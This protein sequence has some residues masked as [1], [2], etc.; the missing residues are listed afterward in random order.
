MATKHIRLPNGFGRITKISN[1]NLR[2]PYRAMVTIGFGEDGRPIGKILKPQ[3]YFRTYNEAYQALMDYHK[4]PVDLM[5]NITVKELYDQWSQYYFKHYKNPSAAR[6]ME[7]AWQYLH[8]YYK[9][10]VAD[11]RAKTIRENLDTAHRIKNGERIEATDATKQKIKL[12][13]N[14]MLDYAVEYE[15]TDRNWAR[16]MKY[17]IK[18]DVNSHISF[19]KEEMETLWKYQCDPYV[20]LVLI[21]CY[22]GWRPSE[23]LEMRLENVNIN[24]MTMK[25]GMKTEAG[26][27]RVVPIPSRIQE[28][29][30]NIYNESLSRGSD[31]FVSQP[32]GKPVSYVSYRNAFEKLKTE[33]QLND[34]HRPHDA[35]KQFVTMAKAA[36]VDDYAIKR[37]V[38]HVIKD[39]TESLYTDRSIEWL[40]TEIE[41][42]GV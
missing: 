25:G 11:I 33:Y 30:K 21:Q 15:M 19:T 37:I 42:I 3:G 7:A 38:G 1:K 14:R 36:G 40:R 31:Y 39:I 13:W 26:R 9:M 24:E 2:N 22:M 10:R 32:N 23:L 29:A 8:P 17:E 41:K 28:I 18:V 16:L 5:Q 20:Q 12:L 4:D 35:R 27:N 34:A 6:V